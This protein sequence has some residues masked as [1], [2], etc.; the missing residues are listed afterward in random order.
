MCLTQLIIIHIITLRATK[1]CLLEAVSRFEGQQNTNHS[2][3][4]SITISIHISLF[5]IGYASCNINIE[6]HRL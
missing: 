1:N 5:K 3:F 6:R 2:F 4:I